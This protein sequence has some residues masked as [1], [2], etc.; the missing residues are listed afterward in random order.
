ML[1]ILGIFG[2]LF[3]LLG[4]AVNDY[5]LVKK[6]GFFQGYSGITWIVISLQVRLVFNC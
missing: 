3:G 2:L 6:S 1:N 5:S 4:V